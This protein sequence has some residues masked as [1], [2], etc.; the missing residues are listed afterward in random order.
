MEGGRDGG[1]RR[2]YFIRVILHC[3]ICFA[4]GGGMGGG[5]EERGAVGEV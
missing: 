4:V 1:R 5:A 2:S 3:V